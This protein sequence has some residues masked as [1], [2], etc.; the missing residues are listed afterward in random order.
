LY[1]NFVQSI[2]GV[3]ALPEG[4]SSGS[5]ISGSSRADRFVMGLLRAQADAVLVGAGTLRGSPGHRWTAE[6]IAPDFAESHRAL[7]ADLGLPAEPRLIVVTGSGA[8][9]VAHTSLERGVTV[10]TTTVG[11]ARLDGRL[12]AGSTVHIAGGGDRVELAALVAY[13]RECGFESVLTEAGPDVNGQL[14][15]EGLLDELFLTVSPV[16]AGSPRAGGFGFAAGTELLPET[17]V[18]PRTLSCRQNGDFLFLR[19]SLR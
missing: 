6:F 2:D 4:K 17:R 8:I 12:P 15:R 11:A 9:D 18:Q 19:Y 5:V 7:R 14:I 1:A 3:V 13:V 16:I 10:V